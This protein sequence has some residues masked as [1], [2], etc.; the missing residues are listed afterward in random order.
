MLVKQLI[1]FLFNRHFARLQIIFV[2]NGCY[3]H[4]VVS[5]KKISITKMRQVI[6]IKAIHIDW[7]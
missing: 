7:I 1:N 5:K 3:S 4:S 6:Q 2:V